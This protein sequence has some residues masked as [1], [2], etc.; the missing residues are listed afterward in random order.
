MDGGVPGVDGVAEQ[1]GHGVAGVVG[2]GAVEGEV[3]E[4]AVAGLARR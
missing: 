4:G 2:E 3:G 1:L